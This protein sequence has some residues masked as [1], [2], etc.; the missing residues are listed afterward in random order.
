MSA[1]TNPSVQGKE[2][3]EVSSALNSDSRIHSVPVGTGVEVS[4]GTSVGADVAVNVS[5]G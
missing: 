3:S 5:V 2:S 4:V 1:I